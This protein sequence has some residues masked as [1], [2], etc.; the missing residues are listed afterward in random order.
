MATIKSELNAGTE[1]AAPPD[2][3]T[4]PAK[5]ARTTCAPA[6]SVAT[7][8]DASKPPTKI[9]TVIK[10]LRRGNGATLD[11]LIDATGWQKHTVRAAL[12][13]LKKKGHDIERT[14]EK[15]VSRY[16]IVKPETKGSV[17]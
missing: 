17:T 13:G 4:R 8:P 7:T 10:L 5:V 14:K 3:H 2:E 1:G 16:V 11:Q 12:T 15:G 9:A 6:A